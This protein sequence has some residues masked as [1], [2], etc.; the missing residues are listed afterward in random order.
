MAHWKCENTTSSIQ[1]DSRTYVVVKA[2]QEVALVFSMENH[3][4]YIN[5]NNLTLNSNSAK[6]LLVVSNKF[7]TK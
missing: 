3:T 4:V 7:H 2:T 6:F 5:E 1:L